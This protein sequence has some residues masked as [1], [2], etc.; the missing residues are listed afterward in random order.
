[1]REPPPCP[2]IPVGPRATP[3]DAPNDAPA[4]VSIDV[5]ATAGK[6]DDIDN[7]DRAPPPPPQSVT[8]STPPPKKGIT[9]RTLPSPPVFTPPPPPPMSP[10]N[11]P[12]TASGSDYT[13]PLPPPPHSPSPPPD[14]TGEIASPKKVG[15][16]DY[17]PPPAHAPPPVGVSALAG[18]REPRAENAA[19]DIQGKATPASNAT[20]T[21]KI[22]TYSGS[23]N[24]SP[25][26][27]P[28]LPAP[29]PPAVAARVGN[30]AND[31]IDDDD[32]EENCKT[33]PESSADGTNIRI[34]IPEPKTEPPR[35]KKPAHPLTPSANTLRNAE[36]LGKPPD[37]TPPP[38]PPPPPTL[39]QASHIKRRMTRKT[40]RDAKVDLIRKTS[41]E[42]G[43]ANREDKPPKRNSG[44][45]KHDGIHVN[46]KRSSLD[47]AREVFTTR[48]SI[49]ERESSS[50]LF[51]QVTGS[52]R[53][54]LKLSPKGEV[55]PGKDHVIVRKSPSSGV[56]KKSETVLKAIGPS[57]SGANVRSDNSGDDV[58]SETPVSRGSR[59]VVAESIQA[60][61]GVE[62]SLNSE[63]EAVKESSDDSAALLAMLSASLSTTPENTPSPKSRACTIDRNKADDVNS[64]SV[65]GDVPVPLTHLGRKYEPHTPRVSVVDESDTNQLLGVN[66]ATNESATK[67][68]ERTDDA[69]T[70]DSDASLVM[71]PTTIRVETDQT[72]TRPTPDDVVQNVKTKRSGEIAPLWPPGVSVRANGVT[73]PSPP[74]LPPPPV[75]QKPG[76]DAKP[77]AP[78][79]QSEAA[80]PKR[81]LGSA[82]VASKVSSEDVASK[83][84]KKKHNRAS[85]HSRLSSLRRL[86]QARKAAQKEKA[87]VQKKKPLKKESVAL[88]KRPGTMYTEVNISSKQAE[89]PGSLISNPRVDSP[90]AGSFSNPLSDLP[91][92]ASFS[93][94][95]ADLPP[96]LPS[97]A[98]EFEPRPKQPP[99]AESA[100]FANPLADLPASKSIANVASQPL[101]ASVDMPNP[102]DLLTSSFQA[103]SVDLGGK[104]KGQHQDAFETKIP[105]L[106]HVGNGQSSD[107]PAQ[108]HSASEIDNEGKSLSVFQTELGPAVLIPSSVT[109]KDAVTRAAALIASSGYSK[110]EEEE[111]EVQRMVEHR[112]LR[113]RTIEKFRR[114]NRADSIFRQTSGYKSVSYPDYAENECVND[115]QYYRRPEPQSLMED[116]HVRSQRSAGLS[117]LMQRTHEYLEK[118]KTTT[119][120]RT[121]LR[122]SP[123]MNNSRGPVQLSSE[124]SGSLS[125]VAS[126]STSKDALLRR[127]LERREAR[128]TAR[129]IEEASPDNLDASKIAVRRAARAARAAQAL[130]A[131]EEAEARAAGT[132]HS[133]EQKE[134]PASYEIQIPEVT[135][136]SDPSASS[137]LP[138]LGSRLSA[139]A[140][141]VSADDFKPPPATSST[142]QVAKTMPV[143]R[144]AESGS[145]DSSVLA[146][147]RRKTTPDAC[148]GDVPATPPKRM[149]S[150]NVRRLEWRKSVVTRAR[151][152]PRDGSTDMP[153]SNRMVVYNDD[154]AGGT[155]NHE[156]GEIKY[157]LTRPLAILGDKR[158]DQHLRSSPNSM[159]SLLQPLIDGAEFVV[160]G[161]TPLRCKF[162]LTPDLRNLRWYSL[163]KLSD[164]GT[165]SKMVGGDIA[166]AKICGV[167]EVTTDQTSESAA[168][169]AERSTYPFEMKLELESPSLSA[170]R[171]Q[172]PVQLCLCTKRE[173]QRRTWIT[174]IFYLRSLCPREYFR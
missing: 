16:H 110:V 37:N 84:E 153:T 33:A 54:S 93:N 56:T 155:Q 2:A 82:F 158:T 69:G 157:A 70:S 167:G 111:E 40:L 5:D 173:E 11:L 79:T 58:T 45:V 53:A 10:S 18:L 17:P 107:I 102:L 24:S 21:L 76:S 125:I 148:S 152:L 26:P 88:G 66:S 137:S 4:N 99:A 134:E 71:V 46:S 81:A 86:K 95:L 65:E 75:V 144:S 39:A 73:P 43:S 112:H 130:Q 135:L 133:I 36:L 121:R 31:H 42:K 114:Q 8:V 142:A 32:H 143:L 7:H 116:P 38:P 128:R 25:P 90:S 138:F 59:L 20:T 150:A 118:Q 127:I 50:A 87:A 27:E 124:S 52:K 101:S 154:S 13:G 136:L 94:P 165:A 169:R 115:R 92:S 151:P 164:R 83:R 163:T 103:S 146:V 149:F 97:S 168:V 3:V 48:R 160:G 6:S 129:S 161:K 80:K 72:A 117:S 119:P 141:R 63:T 171:E 9:L 30:I 174:G 126:T 29:Y 35:R 96:P 67:E 74:T 91:N 23:K 12:I 100:S 98:P 28:L 159:Q 15:V 41:K 172:P 49:F 147:S 55:T 57:H 105:R 113:Q 14:P 34:T 123:S 51:R 156:F 89:L 132:A 122:H 162:V 104:T 68:I 139:S 1:M 64:S 108:K 166:I 47:M 19:A 77:W 131:T 170:E 78:L 120:L 22:R 109:S 85:K 61:Q 62:S 145:E 44:I 60:G 140:H 106:H